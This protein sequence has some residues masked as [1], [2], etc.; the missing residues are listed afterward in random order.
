M[1]GAGER[2]R[3]NDHGQSFLVADT[4][5]VQNVLHGKL[6]TWVSDLLSAWLKRQHNGVDGRT[7][8]VV[9]DAQML[10]VGPGKGRHVRPL[11]PSPPGYYVKYRQMPAGVRTEHIC[12]SLS[13]W[14]TKNR[15]PPYL[16]YNLLPE[17]PDIVGTKLGGGANGTK[18]GS[19]KESS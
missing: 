10:L 15:P 17:N 13:M 5:S 14:Q 18:S 3:W 1:R 7:R 2:D 11:L 8:P 6:V 9:V 16:V 12:P 4:H 19:I